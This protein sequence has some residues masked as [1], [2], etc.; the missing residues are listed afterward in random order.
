MNAPHGSQITL[1]SHSRRA[2]QALAAAAAACIGLATLLPSAQRFTGDPWCIVCGATGSVDVLLNFLLFVPLG[3]GLAMAGVGAPR[4]IAMAF[5]FTVGIETLQFS[6][7]PGRDASLGDIVANSL[8]GAA[9]FAI[10]ARI[11]DLV[12]PTPL[13]ARKLLAA[14]SGI[15]VTVQLVA[16]LALLPANTDRGLVGQIGRA[17]GGRPR[18]PGRVLSATI[19][20][21]AIPNTRFADASH[22][23]HA[24]PRGATV[25]VTVVAPDTAPWWRAPVVRIVDDS[26]SEAL[27]V[28]QDG[29]DLVFGVGTRA[30]AMRLRPLFFVAHDVFPAVRAGADREDT[31]RIRASYTA[32]GVSL[33]VAT[34][35]RGAHTVTLPVTPAAGWR[36]FAPYPVFDDGST[37]NALANLAWLLGL[38]LPAIYWASRSVPPSSSRVIRALTGVT[39]GIV[40]ALLG[41]VV[42]P[43]LMGIGV[44]S[45]WST[46]ALISD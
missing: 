26:L 43:V 44:P 9:G 3:T 45:L 16:S 40:L 7:I 39:A 12:W 24:L 8:G 5:A 19:D 6:V 11:L 18:Y 15:W 21:D 13:F 2:G 29:S 28:G 22:A 23:R 35:L 10:G 1:A 46:A 20:G 31:L 37:R 41:L 27:L 38:L 36:L 32:H 34:S 4:A 25:E 17:L 42:I 33:S 30:A 14:W